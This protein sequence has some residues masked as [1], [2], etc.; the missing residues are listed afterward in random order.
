VAVKQ[1]KRVAD[2]PANC[3]NNP[4]GSGKRKMKIPAGSIEK[5]KQIMC[6][7]Q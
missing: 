4:P 3:G 1:E 2:N 6:R 7:N 5:E